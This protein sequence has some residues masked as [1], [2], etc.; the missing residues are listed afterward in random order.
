MARANY[1]EGPM[2]VTAQTPYKNYTAAPGATLF[3]TDFRLLLASDLVVKVNGAIVT[4][5]FTVSGIGAASADVTFGT[6]RVGGEIIE[7]QRSVS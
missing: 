5:G 7:L 4:A 2:S 3:T 1:C 6:P